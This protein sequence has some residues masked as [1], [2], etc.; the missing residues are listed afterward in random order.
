M[1]NIQNGILFIT[2]SGMN[3]YATDVFDF[4]QKKRGGK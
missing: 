4:G 2:H 1:S 3:G